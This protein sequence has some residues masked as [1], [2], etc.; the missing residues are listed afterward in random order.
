[1]Y[2]ILV[3]DL[4][5]TI[6]AFAELSKHMLSLTGKYVYS[7]NLFEHMMDSN[8]LYLRPG[9]LELLEFVVTA[10]RLLS[11][12]RIVLYTNNQSPEW[13]EYAVHY[14]NKKLS[15]RVFDKVIDGSVEKR[16]TLVKS[17]D[18]FFRWT[19]YPKD[20]SL[21]FV[22][23][24]IHPKMLSKQVVYF[25]ISPYSEPNPAM[26]EPTILLRKEIVAFINKK[27]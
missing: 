22:D 26:R 3:F 18:D 2:K 23:D 7:Y 15:I 16:P 8:H 11:N 6:G 10:R 21:F 5:E 27:N 20:S 4:D 13:V 19:H 14:L 17:V 24:Q 1:M 25:R 9:I 12:V